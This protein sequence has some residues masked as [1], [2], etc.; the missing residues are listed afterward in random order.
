MKKNKGGSKQS[1]KVGI[2]SEY[3]E[4]FPQA[5]TAAISRMVHNENTVDFPTYNSA[6]CMVRYYRDGRVGKQERVR[7][8]E[9][10]KEARRRFAIPESDYVELDP[11]LIPKGQ[12]KI[13]YLTD[14]H[15][16]Y[17][18]VDA[19]EIALEYGYKHGV[20]TLYLNGDIMDCYQVSRW[21]KDRRLRD[22]G[23]ELEMTRV[24]LKMIKKEF[25]CPIYYK[26]G[27][28]ECFDSETEVLTSSGWKKHTEIDDNTMF[29]TYNIDD[30]RI[31]YQSPSK[32]HEYQH[33]GEMVKIKTSLT[34]ILTT[35]NHRYLFMNGGHNQGYGKYK[36]E[37]WSKI[38]KN[39]S[40]MSLL[41]SSSKGSQDNENYSDDEIAISAWLHTDGSI[42]RRDGAN[43]QYTIYQRESN[44]N[45]IDKL[46]SRSGVVFSKK[47]R[48]RDIKNICGKVLLNKPENSVEFKILRGRNGGTAAVANRL[49][50]VDDLIGEKNKLPN[51]WYNLSDRQFKIL[52]DVIIDADGSRH[53]SAP[54]TSL[55][56]YK[57]YEFLSQLQHLCVIHKHRSSL[58]EYKK[59]AWRLNVTPKEFITIDE[60]KDSYEIVNYNGK[61]WC[62]TVPNGTLIVRRNGKVHF[63]G[64]C[65][66]ENFLKMSAPELLGISEFELSTLL[67]FGELG[68]VEI[69]DKQIAKAGKLNLMHGHEFG[70]SVFSPVNPARGLY[71]RAKENS[72][73]GHHHQTSEHSEKN[74]T[75]DVVTTWS[76]GALCGMR[77][78][79]YPYNKWNLGFAII[80]TSDNGD[81]EVN[82]K[83]I[84]EGKV[85]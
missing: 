17:H 76:V 82:N 74:L 59:N 67:R 58:V 18:D 16:P 2:V 68:I 3:I 55:C 32:I 71:M 12:N 29:A 21:V 52:L 53:K 14:I 57:S 44:A 60:F 5:T 80:E 54:E 63:S 15:I 37:E 38:N 6:L 84:I 33:D 62:A 23:G 73:I 70:H 31:E 36:I 30:K 4:K 13:L 35:T 69:K 22:M 9:Q 51:W 78:E 65:R 27:N 46:L 28:H 48:S 10:A 7:S 39:I 56:V 1:Y 19:V 83:R 40:R 24:F 79:Y 50:R 66:W 49:I 45:K 41:C 8:E 20:N 47:V 72:I 77:P 11:Y 75:G 64:N 34:D 42:T 81:F 43:N 25:D 85:R 26:M 61:V